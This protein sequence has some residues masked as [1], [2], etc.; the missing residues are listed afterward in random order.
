MKTKWIKKKRYFFIGFLFFVGIFLF[1]RIDKN[2]MIQKICH[3]QNIGFPIQNDKENQK[4][5]YSKNPYFYQWQEEVVEYEGYFYLH[6]YRD[7]QRNINLNITKLQVQKNG[8]LYALELEELD[9]TDPYEMLMSRRYIGYFY[10]TDDTIYMTATTMEGFTGKQNRRMIWLLQENEEKFLERC[11]IVCCE[12]GTEDRADEQGYHDYVKVD[13]DRRIFYSR[14]DYYYG[15][16]DY[17]LMMW[18]KGKGLVY[19]VHGNGNKNMHVEFGIDL[20]KKQKIDYGYPY[21]LF[22]L[23]E[24]AKAA[25]TEDFDRK[26][27]EE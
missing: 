25:E 13:G 19:Y 20:E 8:I 4:F 26:R 10:V 9:V 14:N 24:I 21:K 7:I 6:T 23:K 11:V 3:P 5:Y 22:H 18:E 12:K 2:C 17:L 1:F 16:K 27:E 15:S